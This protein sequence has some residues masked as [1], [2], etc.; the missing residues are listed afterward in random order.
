MNE[1]YTK[2][3]RAVKVADVLTSG[4]FLVAP[5]LEMSYGEDVAHVHGPLMVVDQVY[6]AAPTEV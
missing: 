6:D 3:G 5:L 4:K 1:K 2:E